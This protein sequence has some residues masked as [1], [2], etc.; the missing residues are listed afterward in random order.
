MLNNLFQGTLRSLS[1]VSPQG[2]MLFSNISLNIGHHRYGLVGPNGVGK[3]T[4]AKLLARQLEPHAGQVLISQPVTYLAQELAR[5]KITIAEFLHTIWENPFLESQLWIPLLGNLAMDRKLSELSGGEWMRVRIIQSLASPTGLLILDEPTNNLDS[6][7]R[8]L[9]YEFVQDYPGALLIISHDRE[10]LSFVDSILELSNLGISIYGG[11]YDFYQQEKIHER[12]VLSNKIDSV[13]REKNKLASEATEK[14]EAQKKRMRVGQ[15]K[16][17]RGGMPKILIGARKRQAQKSL[18]NIHVREKARIEISAEELQQLQDNQKLES[19][20]GLELTETSLA[21]GKMVFD[22]QELNFKFQESES[23]LWSEKIS[24]QMQGPRKWAL[25]GAN[26]AGKSTFL[27]LLLSQGREPEGNCEGSI[28]VG[29][30]RTAFIDQEYSILNSEL[31]V[32]ENIHENSGL[33]EKQLR[34]MLAHFQFYA[35]KVFQ[36]VGTLS[37]GEKLKASLAKA[38]LRADPPQF[39]ILDE[40]TNNLD[41]GSLEVLERVLG[42]FKGALLVVSHDERFLENIGIEQFIK[43]KRVGS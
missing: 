35:E 20:L 1:W 36:V 34:N 23:W 3:S 15:A 39:L 31:S 4:L 38:L 16:A 18:A 12:K 28:G 5:S 29:S 7:A 40:P 11:S 32:I 24:L 14:M 10:L 43:L 21:E 37:G 42:A 41:L 25:R 27:K 33:D 30:L 2:Q 26:G 13:R 9:I 8:E 22:C 6:G 17:D 19:H